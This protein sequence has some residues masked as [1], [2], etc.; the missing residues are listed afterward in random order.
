[1]ETVQGLS[2][3]FWDWIDSRAIVRRASVVVCLYLTIVQPI[4]AWQFAQLKLYP[5]LEVAAIIAAVLTPLAALQGAV[6][7]FYFDVR[8]EERKD[9]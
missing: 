4:A 9:A 8:A 6:L 7:K 3:R 1:M 2:A 5:G